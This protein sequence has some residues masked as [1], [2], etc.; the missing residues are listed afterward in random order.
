MTTEPKMKYYYFW[1]R[2]LNSRED[3][4][5][6]KVKAKSMDEARKIVQQKLEWNHRFGISH[7]FE[8]GREFTKY[9]GWPAKWA[10]EI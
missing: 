2:N 4:E 3:N 10:Q 1:M 7:Q 9:T 8:T 6:W 5:A